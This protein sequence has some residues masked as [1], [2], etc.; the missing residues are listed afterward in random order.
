MLSSSCALGDSPIRAVV[1]QAI[2]F[3]VSDAQYWQPRGRFQTIQWFL[4]RGVRVERDCALR[5]AGFFSLLHPVVV[6]VGPDPI[7]PFL[8]M[9]VLRGPL[10]ID[11]MFM[12]S[13]DPG[14]WDALG[15][16]IHFDTTSALPTSG[17][18]LLYNVLIEADINVRRTYLQGLTMAD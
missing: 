1:R 18:D 5:T 6:L 3:L 2:K 11:E 12:R 10:S 4:K 8:L 17:D 13:M 15:P 9:R 14:M 7:S 16:W